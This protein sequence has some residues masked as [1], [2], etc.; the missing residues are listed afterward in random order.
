MHWAAEPH[1]SVFDVQSATRVR[2]GIVV[3]TAAVILAALGVALAAR[4]WRPPLLLV[5]GALLGASLLLSSFGFTSAYR[6]LLT[7]GDV[8]G[9]AAQLL[10][11]ALA[12]ILFAPMLAAGEALGR[13]VV[14]AIAPFGAQVAIGAF[15]FGIGMQ[16]AGG[17]GS[18]TLF[19]LGGGSAR[20]VV[21]LLFF[22]LG[23]FWASLHFGW[24]MRL[25]SLGAISL[26]ASLG[27]A[28]GVA[29]QL[30]VL[31]ALAGLCG[32]RRARSGARPVFAIFDGAGWRWPLVVG[33][34]ALAVLNAATLVVA[35]HPWSIT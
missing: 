21:T 35:G 32:W 17:C 8:S 20:M 23:S 15:L 10:M 3:V 29:A 6:K 33:A 18:G 19:A 4:G 5:I 1:R 31:A 7:V 2:Q 27:W 24:W 13:P 30:A 16:L 28:S 11:L 9:L 22:C 12:T 25:P 14:G 34:V 26:G